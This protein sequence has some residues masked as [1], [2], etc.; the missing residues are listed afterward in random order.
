MNDIELENAINVVCG[1]CYN[2]NPH[3]CDICPVRTLY[4]ERFNDGEYN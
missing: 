3:I 4:I 1:A 2:H